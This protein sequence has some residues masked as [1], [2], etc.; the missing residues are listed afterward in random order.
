MMTV[1]NEAAIPADSPRAVM[2]EAVAFLGTYKTSFRQKLQRASIS[3]LPLFS[4]QKMC[5]RKKLTAA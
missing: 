4:N 3:F 1:A 5:K 2:E